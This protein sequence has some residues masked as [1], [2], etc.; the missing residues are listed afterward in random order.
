MKISVRLSRILRTLYG[1]RLFN[2]NFQWKNYDV[3]QDAWQD[4]GLTVR[5]FVPEGSS[6]IEFGAGKA[7]FREYFAERNLY[8]ATDVVK[9]QEIDAI[10]NLNNPPTYLQNFD[11]GIA[12]GVLEYLTDL[13][14]SMG[15]IS[16]KCENFIFSYC[17]K[18]PGIKNQIKRNLNGWRSHLWLDELMSIMNNYGYTVLHI[19][20]IESTLY[21]DQY[22]FV[23]ARTI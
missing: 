17:G 19:E 13:P 23:V 5:K 8:V 12:L 18:I 14:K 16:Q 4:R 22:L 20:M 11:F 9:R 7:M 2:F 15:F 6:V 1:V 3:L 10:L 21:F